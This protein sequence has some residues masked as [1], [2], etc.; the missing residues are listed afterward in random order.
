V[1]D[2]NY[3]RAATPPA[4]THKSEEKNFN[5]NKSSSP[6]VSS[7]KNS[8]CKRCYNVMPNDLQNKIK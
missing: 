3:N 2:F 1:R 6:K 4:K 5:H 7:L 8:S